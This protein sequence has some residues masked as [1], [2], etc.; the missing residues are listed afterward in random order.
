MQSIAKEKYKWHSLFLVLCGGNLHWLLNNLPQKC[1]LQ[2]KHSRNVCTWN[3]G[4]IKDEQFKQREIEEGFEKTTLQC[5][6]MLE[7]L[8][9]TNGHPMK[10]V[11]KR[12]SSLINGA[13]LHLKH[14]LLVLVPQKQKNLQLQLFL[15]PLWTLN[16]A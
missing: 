3:F 7:L 5:D 15:M 12:R 8:K 11:L 1:N 13:C 9:T 2:K 4:G 10:N 14:P 16:P 6:E